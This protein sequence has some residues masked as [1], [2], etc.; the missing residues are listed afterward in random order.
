MIFGQ[1]KNIIGVNSPAE[2]MVVL[3]ELRRILL[4]VPAGAPMDGAIAHPNR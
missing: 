2:L 3:E 1:G 4:T